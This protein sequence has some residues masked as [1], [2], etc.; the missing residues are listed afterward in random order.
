MFGAE[1]ALWPSAAKKVSKWYRGVLEAAKRFMVRWR[2]N[3]A[4][5]SRQRH[6]S[7]MGG[8]QGNGEGRGKSSRKLRLKK[9]GR[10]RQ[11]G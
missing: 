3:E 4:K 7:V 6:V 8:V 2:E 11:T 5:L 1:T 9:A 10:R